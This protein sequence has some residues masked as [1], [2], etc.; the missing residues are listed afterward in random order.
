MVLLKLISTKR[1]WKIWNELIRLTTTPVVRN[2]LRGII[3]SGAV[4]MLCHT[5]L[6][7]T[8]RTINWGNNSHCFV[9]TNEQKWIQKFLVGLK[10]VSASSVEFYMNDCFFRAHSLLA[11]DA[12]YFHIHFS[13]FRINPENR[14]STASE[15]SANLYQNTRCHISQGG[16]LLSHC[17]ENYISHGIC[18]WDYALV[19]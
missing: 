12:V 2:E 19:I 3:K 10:L 16:N 15:T 9:L 7:L 17:C 6:I 18:S 11:C 5:G 1:N 8:G 14:D 13:L 4:L